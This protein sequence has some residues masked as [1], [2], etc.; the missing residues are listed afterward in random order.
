VLIDLGNGKVPED[1]GDDEDIVHRQAL[2]DHKSGQILNAGLG[3]EGEPDP[4]PE[5]EAQGQIAE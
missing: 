4:T 3:A 1:H 5:A 2:F